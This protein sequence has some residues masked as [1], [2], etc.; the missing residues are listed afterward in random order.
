V[1]APA[2]LAGELRVEVEDDGTGQDP[3]AG[4]GSGLLGMRERVRAY[5]GEVLAGPR[6]P[7]GWRVCARLD[8]DAA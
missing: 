7:R 6:V 3:A 1:G 8:L 4:P 2:V 5:V